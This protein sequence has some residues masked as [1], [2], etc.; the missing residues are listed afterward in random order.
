MNSAVLPK[1]TNLLLKGK[2]QNIPLKNETNNSAI[3]KKKDDTII[4]LE[5]N[6][7][8]NRTEINKGYSTVKSKIKSSYKI[9]TQQNDKTSNGNISLSKTMVHQ[10]PIINKGRA[11]EMDQNLESS[12][13][14]LT[15]SRS[16]KYN[17]VTKNG[18]K[19]RNIRR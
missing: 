9:N 13:K 14:L 4:P 1:T 10:S 6:I 12:G 5:Q 11:I 15:S 3:I 8:P 17:K 19:I 16:S 7:N 18:K 2:D